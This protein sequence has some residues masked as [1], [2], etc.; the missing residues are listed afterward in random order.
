M[1]ITFMVVY[2]MRSFWEME[3]RVYTFRA[4]NHFVDISFWLEE[5]TFGELEKDKINSDE[6]FK[7]KKQ[8]KPNLPALK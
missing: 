1:F 4:F 6:L 3:N 2:S 8:E 7:L 5:Q